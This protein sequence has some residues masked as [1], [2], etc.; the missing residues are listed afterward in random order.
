MPQELVVVLTEFIHDSDMPCAF[1]DTLRRARHYAKEVVTGAAFFVPNL[2]TSA[3]D[4]ISAAVAA[5][6]LGALLK[7]K[8]NEQK[9]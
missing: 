4:N 8:L 2:F 9:Q 5:R 1:V 6:N 3:S 7:A